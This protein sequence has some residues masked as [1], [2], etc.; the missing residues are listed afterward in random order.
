MSNNEGD[1]NIEISNRL[2]KIVQ[3]FASSKKCEL[4]SSEFTFNL[5]HIVHDFLS[6]QRCIR[7]DDWS[8]IGQCEKLGVYCVKKLLY[9]LVAINSETL[10]LISKYHIVPLVELF[11]AVPKL[12]IFWESASTLANLKSWIAVLDKFTKNEFFLKCESF[13]SLRN[14]VSFLSQ[15]L[16]NGFN[17]PFA[18]KWILIVVASF[19][20]EKFGSDVK[21][22]GRSYLSV[23]YESISQLTLMVKESP[24]CNYTRI[25]RILDG[26]LENVKV[27]D[28]LDGL[29][30]DTT[31]ASLEPEFEA[32]IIA[33][34]C[35]NAVL[36]FLNDLNEVQGL[37][38]AVSCMLNLV[39]EYL[40][41][42]DTLSDCYPFLVFIISVLNSL[43][44]VMGKDMILRPYNTTTVNPTDNM[45]SSHNFNYDSSI[46]C[47][48]ECLIE[49]SC[50]FSSKKEETFKKFTKIL[51][52]TSVAHLKN[53]AKKEVEDCGFDVKCQ[54]AQLCVNSFRKLHCESEVTGIIETSDPME[55]LH[56]LIHVMGKLEMK[57]VTLAEQIR[58]I[59]FEL[60]ANGKLIND[61]APSEKQEPMNDSSKCWLSLQKLNDFGITLRC[62]Q[63]KSL[64][65]KGREKTGQNLKDFCANALKAVI[66]GNFC[67]D[68]SEEFR[69]ANLQSVL[70][71]MKF[72]IDIKLMAK[73]EM[74][75]LCVKLFV[76]TSRKPVPERMRK[77]FNC[78]HTFVEGESVDR[79]N[80]KLM[81]G[82]VF[83]VEALHSSEECKL[84]IDSVVN[85]SFII[86][87]LDVSSHLFEEFTKEQN[88]SS[89]N[90]FI[91]TLDVYMLWTMVACIFD[92]LGFHLHS[93]KLW[94][95]IAC[96]MFKR[97]IASSWN[98]VN[99]HHQFAE[100]LQ[101]V[102]FSGFM[103]AL[104]CGSLDIASKF[105]C[106]MASTEEKQ[107]DENFDTFYET[108]IQLKWDCIAKRRPVEDILL[109]VIA[110]IDLDAPQVWAFFKSS[111]CIDFLVVLLAEYDINDV[112]HDATDASNENKSASTDVIFFTKWKAEAFR[113]WKSFIRRCIVTAPDQKHLLPRFVD[114]NNKNF[115]SALMLPS[116]ILDS[117]AE[118]TFM[119]KSTGLVDLATNYDTFLSDGGYF[120]PHEKLPEV[121]SNLISRAVIELAFCYSYAGQFDKSY[122]KLAEVVHKM[123]GREFDPKS[124]LVNA[125]SEITTNEAGDVK[126]FKAQECLSENLAEIPVSDLLKEF[127]NNHEAE[128]MCVLCSNIVKN[129]NVI[130]IHHLYETI[131][132]KSKKSR[133]RAKFLMEKLNGKILSQCGLIST[134]L[135]KHFGQQGSNQDV[136]VKQKRLKLK[137]CRDGF[138]PAYNCMGSVPSLDNFRMFS[139]GCTKQAAEAIFVNACHLGSDR[140]SI[141][142]ATS[143]DGSNESKTNNETGH[144]IYEDRLDL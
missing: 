122:E 53:I 37:D 65:E 137:E 72:V 2:K 35:E 26:R 126:C 69:D 90:G 107:N 105:C 76:G 99:D 74:V 133:N 134:Y 66:D 28:L 56:Y 139:F 44:K 102:K 47:K 58:A 20:G 5:Q 143:N 55:Y 97:E 75:P 59:I 61:R 16:L 27:I 1:A 54:M 111:L 120:E 119:L 118:L 52:N 42:S 124:L 29:F 11:T 128:C 15:S 70:L 34:R 127:T 108:F 86:N 95:L 48:I 140:K 41:I 25:C 64:F 18:I 60:V 121:Y 21:R 104:R 7:I 93:L 63:L 141:S 81:E 77:V 32:F 49:K 136:A 51:L 91:A 67:S 8:N 12:A 39:E 24:N 138:L 68:F 115:I 113:F 109:D 92:F 73:S 78:C 125:A 84:S 103:T 71:D 117:Y 144:E 38:S 85:H 30:G 131:P 45:K 88:F 142:E 19:L 40:G 82:V 130:L 31:V 46:F 23:S 112:I 83:F 36:H 114:A 33:L 106:E 132:R 17:S 89:S 101:F 79:W 80:L 10:R 14:L 98:G 50:C 129:E 4:L 110:F 94:T 96:K 57:N 6:P 87:L 100:L 13:A 116:F 62:D 3:F 43:V 123:L 135:S 9:E 22:D